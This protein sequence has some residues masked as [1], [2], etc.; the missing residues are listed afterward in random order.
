MQDLIFMLAL[1]GFFLLT[2]LF[3]IGCDRIIGSDEAALAEDQRGAP[4]PEPQP[5]DVLERRAA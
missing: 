3:V 4:A 1:V 5:S 2:G